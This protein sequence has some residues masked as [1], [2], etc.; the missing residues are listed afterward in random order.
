MLNSLL[1]S[2]ATLTAAFAALLAHA[3]DTIHG[4]GATFPAPLYAEWIDGYRRAT[5]ID[6]AYDAVGSGAGID[7]IRR[8]EVDFGATDA[9]L[10][11]E[12][13]SQA[14]LVQFPLVLGGVVP[15]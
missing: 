4:A 12:E 11:A 6:V 3:A 1:R 5:G 7:A 8:H 10:S 14:Q 15:V 2:I 9:P 13:L